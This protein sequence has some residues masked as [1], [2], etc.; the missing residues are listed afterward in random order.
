MEGHCLTGQSPQW[1]CSANGRRRRSSSFIFLETNSL[2]CCKMHDVTSVVAL[3]KALYMN[4]P[5]E[6]GQTVNVGGSGR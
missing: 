4:S 2:E 1:A 3:C 6:L 5:T